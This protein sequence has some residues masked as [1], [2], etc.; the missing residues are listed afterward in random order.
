[1]VRVPLDAV[2]TGVFGVA[3]VEPV[4]ASKD[5]ASPRKMTF[6]RVGAE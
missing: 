3:F 2:A 6:E 4:E 5:E 1:M